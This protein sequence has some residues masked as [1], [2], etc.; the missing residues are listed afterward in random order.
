M[1]ETNTYN[2]RFCFRKHDKNTSKQQN[3]LILLFIS[4]PI[5]IVGHKCIMDHTYKATIPP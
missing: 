5:K 2:C 4:M 1:S 3:A